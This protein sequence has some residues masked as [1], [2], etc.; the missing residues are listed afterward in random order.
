M[1]VLQF[2]AVLVINAGYLMMVLLPAIV[3]VVLGVACA[4]AILVWL[5]DR[6]A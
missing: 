1:F 4:R 3:V 6:H 5:R 2:S